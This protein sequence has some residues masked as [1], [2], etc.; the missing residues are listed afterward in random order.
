MEAQAKL[1]ENAMSRSF[2]A[3]LDAERKRIA[4]MSAEQQQVC[5]CV[6]A[7]LCVC[8]RLCAFMPVCVRPRVRVFCVVPAECV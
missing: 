8:L 6:C 1:K 4:A 2:E 3:R 5:V 7:C